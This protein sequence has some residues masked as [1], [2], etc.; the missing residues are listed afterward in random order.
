[1]KGR[2]RVVAEVAEEDLGEGK[3]HIAPYWRVLKPDGSL[4]E[5]TSVVL[6]GRR[7]F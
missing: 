3:N 4:S 7:F 2:T 5:N 6:S 1:M